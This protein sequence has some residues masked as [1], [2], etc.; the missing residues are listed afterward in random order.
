MRTTY[1]DSILQDLLLDL[2]RD[3]VSVSGSTDPP[4]LPGV[5]ITEWRIA[6]SEEKK[7]E[8]RRSTSCG[9]SRPYLRFQRQ[10]LHLP[11]RWFRH[12]NQS[13]PRLCRTERS[14]ALD[15]SAGLW[16]DPRLSASLA[17]EV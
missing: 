2:G 15:G 13:L 1:V 8:H 17:G 6:A 11:S 14:T 3:A 4:F 10:R 7:N 5:D 9:T 16:L 12:K